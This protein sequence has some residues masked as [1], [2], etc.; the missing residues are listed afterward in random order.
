M[1]SGMSKLDLEWAWWAKFFRIRESAR[2]LPAFEPAKA[3]M[4]P[5]QPGQHLGQQFWPPLRGGRG[6]RT[7]DDAGDAD[8]ADEDA[9]E[10]DSGEEGQDDDL[11]ASRR[12]INALMDESLAAMQAVVVANDTAGASGDDADGHAPSP[13]VSSSSSSSSSSDDGSSSNEAIRGDRGSADVA[14]RAPGG[15]L[16]FYA[17]KQQFAATCDN[18]L[19]G[20]CVMTRQSTAAKASARTPNILAKGRPLGYLAAWLAMGPGH[21]SKDDHWDKDKQPTLEARRAARL[22]LA[23][24][25][26]G[27]LLLSHERPKRA[28]EDDE[29]PGLP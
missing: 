28:G 23:E 3:F 13:D 24:H 29:P 20:K 14:F 18:H 9:D 16:R 25:H 1:F 17:N 27:R 11:V 5:L 2:L 21:T 26:H 15:I 22:K 7:S 4:C 6:R 8:D 12:E 19:H 10:D